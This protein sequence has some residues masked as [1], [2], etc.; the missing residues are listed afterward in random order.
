MNWKDPFGTKARKAEKREAEF[1]A[2]ARACFSHRIRQRADGMYHVEMLN[3]YGEWMNMPLPKGVPDTYG[4]LEYVIKLGQEREA[5]LRREVEERIKDRL[6]KENTFYPP[7]Y[8]K[9][10]DNAGRSH[11]DLMIGAVQWVWASAR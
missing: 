8:E 4:T 11:D 5:D 7:G 2:A 10:S 3:A 1:L 6:E 9:V